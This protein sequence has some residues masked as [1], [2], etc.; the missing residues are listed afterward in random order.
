MDSV[1]YEEIKKNYNV[2]LS[3]GMTRHE[4]TVKFH[5]MTGAT[6]IA[7]QKEEIAFLS[8]KSKKGGSK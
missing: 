5:G 2:L 6:V 8:R 4:Y 3:L 7:K 1:Q